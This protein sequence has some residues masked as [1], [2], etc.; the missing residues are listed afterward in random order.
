MCGE[1]LDKAYQNS[2][3]LGLREDQKNQRSSRVGGC[4]QDSGGTLITPIY[5][6]SIQ[7]RPQKYHSSGVKIMPQRKAYNRPIQAKSKSKPL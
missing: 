7:L 5:S 3:I 1:S 6:P 4:C 2:A